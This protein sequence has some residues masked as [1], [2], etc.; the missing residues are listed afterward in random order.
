ML[1]CSWQVGDKSSNWHLRK[2]IQVAW[3]DLDVSWGERSRFSGFPRL[4]VRYNESWVHNSYDKIKE[5]INSRDF[6]E[7][8]S[9]SLVNLIECIAQEKLSDWRSILLY[10]SFLQ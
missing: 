6:E 1:A 8:K 2:I 5:G 4:R 3:N 10:N 9:R 7:V